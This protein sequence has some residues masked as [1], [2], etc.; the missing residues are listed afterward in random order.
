MSAPHLV[1]PSSLQ[2]EGWGESRKGDKGPV[3]AVP[4]T[5]RHL[6]FRQDKIEA[7]RAAMRNAALVCA[8]SS[9]HKAEESHDA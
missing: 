7:L 2:G 6:Y 1:S 8:L 4:F 5:T 9:S 3:L